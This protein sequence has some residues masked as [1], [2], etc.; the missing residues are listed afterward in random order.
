MDERQH[1]KRDKLGVRVVCVSD[2]HGRHADIKVPNGDILIHAGDFTHFGKKKDII[3]F[4]EW[5]GTLPHK[6][7]IVVNGN[8]EKNAEWK[9]DSAKLLS[10]C[11]FFLK[12]SMV[13][14]EVSILQTQAKQQESTDK[15]N[16]KNTPN[17]DPN[18]D[19]ILPASSTNTIKVKAVSVGIYGT[20]FFWP[21]PSSNPYYDLIPKEGVDILVAHGPAK[22]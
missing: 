20:D 16:D 9:K 17:E 15:G 10:N 14:L 5:L 6:H 18:E 7:K 22:G 4:N 3:A 8:H 19:T 21:C 2:T 13:T 11:S 12:D 1:L